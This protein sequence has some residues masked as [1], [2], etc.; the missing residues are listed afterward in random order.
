[1]YMRNKK[2]TLIG[3]ISNG[4]YLDA[5]AW[6][7]AIK[8]SDKASK[9]IIYHSLTDLPKLENDDIVDK[10]VEKYNLTTENVFMDCTGYVY[11]SDLIVAN[12]LDPYSIGTCFELG[13]AWSLGIPIYA[14]ASDDVAKHPFIKEA[15]TQIVRSVSE[16]IELL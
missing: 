5:I 2:L 15:C 8:A 13:L 4:T 7:E 14:I 6:R 3:K 11:A 12:L 16:V 10:D 1:M 9:Y